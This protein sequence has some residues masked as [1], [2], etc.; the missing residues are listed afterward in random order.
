MI[1]TE[2]LFKIS[3]KSDIWM[4]QGNDENNI[5]KKTNNKERE[6]GGNLSTNC[7]GEE[8]WQR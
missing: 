5:K 1:I 3:T 7:L 2:K 4:K 8:L 6:E